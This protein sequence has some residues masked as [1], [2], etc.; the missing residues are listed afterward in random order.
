MFKEYFRNES[1]VN[2]VICALAGSREL[3]SV[4]CCSADTRS[5]GYKWKLFSLN[6]EAQ[7]A[8]IPMYHG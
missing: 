7:D 4:S 2:G 6:L 3:S 8:F 5:V 1:E